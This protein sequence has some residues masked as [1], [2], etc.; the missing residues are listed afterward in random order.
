MFQLVPGASVWLAQS[1]APEILS[2][3]GVYSNEAF[4]LP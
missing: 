3:S 1:D 4:G 2:G